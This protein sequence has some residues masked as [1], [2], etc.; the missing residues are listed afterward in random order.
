M[1]LR[2]LKLALSALSRETSGERLRSP[3]DPR[4][5]TST[6]KILDTFRYFLPATLRDVSGSIRAMITKQV[7]DMIARDQK[8]HLQPNRAA[9]TPPMIGPTLGAEFV[10]CSCEFSGLE[11][12]RWACVMPLCWRCKTYL[13][14]RD[15]SH[16]GASISRTCDIRNHSIR[17][18]KDS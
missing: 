4:H 14:K 3:D 12:S 16:K 13:P 1:Q 9:R 2:G 5:G 17:Y 8:I 7:P 10:L 18:C 15:Y 11:L 6:L